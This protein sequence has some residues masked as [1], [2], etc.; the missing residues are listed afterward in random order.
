MFKSQALLFG[1]L[2]SR[3]SRAAITFSCLYSTLHNKAPNRL[4]DYS[5]WAHI[6]SAITYLSVPSPLADL[7]VP[8]IILR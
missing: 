2:T 7:P 1:L 8:Y 5:V 4:D 6:T 3:L